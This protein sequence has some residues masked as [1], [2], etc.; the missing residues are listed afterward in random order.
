MW[1]WRWILAADFNGDFLDGFGGGAKSKGG[2][3][4]RDLGLRLGGE[5]EGRGFGVFARI[6][7]R[8]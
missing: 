6:A 3:L 2:G 8:F 7:A 4:R 5:I 1:I